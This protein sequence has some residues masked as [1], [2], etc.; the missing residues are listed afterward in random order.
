[1]FDSLGQEWVS[2]RVSV[3]GGEREVANAQAFLTLFGAE[4]RK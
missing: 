4:C 3:C 1:M 2:K